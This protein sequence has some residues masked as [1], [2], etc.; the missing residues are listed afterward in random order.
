[1]PDENNYEDPD[2]IQLAS[3][4]S[5]PVTEEDIKLIARFHET[6]IGSEEQNETY[7]PYEEF[8]NPTTVKELMEEHPDFPWVQYI[9]GVT[10]GKVP[11]H[12]KLTLNI[13]PREF[14]GRLS[15]AL[16]Q[17]DQHVISKFQLLSILRNFL[18][19][20]KMRNRKPA[21]KCT[22]DMIKHFPVAIN[23]F[24]VTN[25]KDEEARTLTTSMVQKLVT[26]FDIILGRTSIFDRETVAL[27]REKLRMMRRNLGYSD[28]VLDRDRIEEYYGDLNLTELNYYQ[29]VRKMVQ[30]KIAEDYKVYNGDER[31]EEIHNLINP[32]DPPHHL[33]PENRLII[34]LS[35]FHYRT[36]HHELPEYLNFA[37]LGLIVAHELMHGFDLAGRY[38]NVNGEI[39]SWMSEASLQEFKKTEDCLRGQYEAF[40][41]GNMVNFVT[42][43]ENTG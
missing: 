29:M 16:Q 36:L 35:L 6:L 42:F 37:G 22:R 11:V 5:V 1:M 30:F 19:T 38:F 26:Q 9:E 32:F 24:F 20:M 34:G 40:F 4:L 25:H 10:L 14:S 31:T 12:E 43:C 15:A 18:Q 33:M 8:W 21:K 2:L 27:A 7:S 41:G 13:Y 28:L 17:T 3:N 39:G 23:H